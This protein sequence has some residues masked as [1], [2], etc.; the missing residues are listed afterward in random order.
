M[1]SLNKFQGGNPNGDYEEQETGFQVG[2]FYHLVLMDMMVEVPETIIPAGV[3]V[4]QIVPLT[5]HTHRHRLHRTPSAAALDVPLA[6]TGQ[7]PWL[8]LSFPS[9]ATVHPILLDYEAVLILSLLQA[10]LVSPASELT[11]LSSPFSQ[12]IFHKTHLSTPWAHRFLLII[13]RWPKDICFNEWTHFSV[14]N[15]M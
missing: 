15:R 5:F 13:S 3:P 12:L 2:W 7:C 9:P 8:S 10:G 14:L 4:G 6:P 11:A 1:F